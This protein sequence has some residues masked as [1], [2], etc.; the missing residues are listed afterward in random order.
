LYELYVRVRSLPIQVK[1]LIH[2]TI[3]NIYLYT[4]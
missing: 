4:E 3:A 1:L 2:I